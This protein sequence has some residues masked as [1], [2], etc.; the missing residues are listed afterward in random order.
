[1]PFA[2]C[3]AVAVRVGQ[4]GAVRLGCVPIGGHVVLG[5]RLAGDPVPLFPFGGASWLVVGVQ[6]EAPAEWAASF[7]LGEQNQDAAVE[8]GCVLAAP[9]GPVVG[10]SGVVRGRRAED[11]TVP[12]DLCPAESGYPGVAFA[13]A[14][15]PPVVA[16]GVGPAVVT[17]DD[18]RLR[19]VLVAVAGPFVGELPQA[20]VQ[21]RE[22][23]GRC[24][25]PVVVRPSRTIGLSSRGPPPRSHLAGHASRRRGDV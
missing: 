19:L 14:E 25:A 20:V 1:V 13:V 22:G 16:G 15:D 3:P 6:E 8:Q 12:D 11:K 18:P 9:F 4:A 7:L 23:P 10:Q 21:G 2:G 24:R 17:G 5:D